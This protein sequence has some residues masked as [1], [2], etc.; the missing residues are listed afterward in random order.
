[1]D[2][3]SLA[4]LSLLLSYAKHQKDAD[5]HVGLSF[6][7]TYNDEAF[8]PYCEVAD[9]L[10]QKQRLLDDQRRFSQRYAMLERPSSD[11]PKVAVKSSLFVGR[12][13]ELSQLQANF[14]QRDGLTVSVVSGEAGH[15]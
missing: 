8:Q 15:W 5:K 4:I 2:D 12:T 1:M 9:N 10:K 3:N 7:Y 11:I 13:N 14:E 6:V